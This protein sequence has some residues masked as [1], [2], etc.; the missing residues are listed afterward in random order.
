MPSSLIDVPINSINMKFDAK[1]IHSLEDL[2]EFMAEK[3]SRFQDEVNRQNRQLFDVLISSLGTA[4]YTDKIVQS[5]LSTSLGSQSGT[6]PGFSGVILPLAAYNFIPH[7]VVEIPGSLPHWGA[8]ISFLPLVADADAPDT[9]LLNGGAGDQ[10]Y[11]AEWR[12]ID[13]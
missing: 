12:H 6:V 9:F 11:A 5:Q 8:D 3:F 10:L 2:A 1:D 4:A 13:A 7:A